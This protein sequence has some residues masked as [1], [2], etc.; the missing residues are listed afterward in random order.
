MAPA[1]D[2]DRSIYLTPEEGRLRDSVALACI[3]GAHPN[4][5]GLASLG[6]ERSDLFI[7]ALVD[8]A[9]RYADEVIMRRRKGVILPDRFWNLGDAVTATPSF[10]PGPWIMTDDG[11]VGE[12]RIADGSRR[13]ANVCAPSHGPTPESSANGL[14]LA[15]APELY[16]ALRELVACKDLRA[17]I[18]RGGTDDEMAE[19]ST[20]YERRQP[21]TWVRARV[22]LAKVHA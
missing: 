10:T 12:I 14:L 9:Y 3:Q 2:F 13:I 1:P 20:D 5:V 15:A 18:A 22:A 6:S 21:M 7:A 17:R 4:H 8:Q 16:E 19:W 11:H